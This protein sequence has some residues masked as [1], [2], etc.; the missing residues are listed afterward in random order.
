MKSA[1][2]FILRM[3]LPEALEVLHYGLAAT[4]RFYDLYG[5]TLFLNNIAHVYSLQEDYD[6]ALDTYDVALD[7][8]ENKLDDEGVAYLIKQ[9]I[10][11]MESFKKGMFLQ[12][13]DQPTFMNFTNLMEKH[14]KR[15]NRPGFEEDIQNLPPEVQKK[16]IDYKKLLNEVMSE[17]NPPKKKK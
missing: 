9:N 2:R 14:W 11:D 6:K 5:Q 7:I 3:Q 8:A 13:K 10:K 17:A 16:L 1:E 15:I 12:V 4:G